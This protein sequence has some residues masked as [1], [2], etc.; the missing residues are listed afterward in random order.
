MSYDDD[1]M[2]AAHQDCLNLLKTDEY[3][4]IL[5]IDRLCSLKD[6]WHRGFDHLHEKAEFWGE[7]EA[8]MSLDYWKWSDLK[9]K[10]KPCEMSEYMRLKCADVYNGG[11]LTKESSMKGY[12]LVYKNLKKFMEHVHD[13]YQQEIET[14]HSHCKKCKTRFST[15]LANWEE[16]KLDEN[17]C[18][19][20]E[21][22]V[23]R[24]K[25]LML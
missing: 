7:P 5:E 16:N 23:Q 13:G 12:E 21:D 20:T 3:E 15:F 8:V 2:R 24:L 17:F 18:R 19:D 14:L 25:S 22:I 11:E 1:E 4:Q 10:V 6:S 9:C